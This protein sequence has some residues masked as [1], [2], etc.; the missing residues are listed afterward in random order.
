MPLIYA[1]FYFLIRSTS[2]EDLNRIY[3]KENLTFRQYLKEN[4]T[5]I[6]ILLLSSLIVTISYLGLRVMDYLGYISFTFYPQLDFIFL[7]ILLLIGPI[8]TYNYF[9]AQKKK[10]IQY[11]LPN[12]LIEVDSLSTGA[13]P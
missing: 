2:L 5:P 12:F 3:S 9:E 11:R 8:G 10:Q 4:E 1:G 13:T 7:A 6:M